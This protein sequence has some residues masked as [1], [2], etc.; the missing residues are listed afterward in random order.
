MNNI[1][2]LGGGKVGS[3]IGYDLSQD[4][5]VTV[6]DINRDVLKN[7]KSK[8]NFKTLYSDFLDTN[9][10]RNIL[11]EYDLIISAVP[12]FMG[13]KTLKTIIEEN[14]NVVDISFF[15]ENALELDQLAKKNN[16]TALV[17]FGVAP[18]LG[19]ILFGHYDTLMEIESYECYVGGL[20]KHK[21]PPFEYKAP[22]SPIDVI[23]EYTRPAR[24]FQNSKIITKEPLTDLET[25]EFEE[26]GELEAFNTD[27]LRSLLYTMSHVPYMKEKTLRYK[28]HSKKIKLLKD[29]GLF[30]YNERSINNIKYRPI[31]FTS[32]ILKENWRLSEYEEEFTVMRIICQ[33]QNKKIQI[34]LYDEYNQQTKITSMART[35]GYTCTAGANL[36][37][38]NMFNDVGV[39]PPELIGRKRI[40]HDFILNYIKERDINL[41][42]KTT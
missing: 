29:I 38:K 21:N 42:I 8:Y 22:F 2:V 3:A 17:D 6:A 25:I 33:N 5:S 15:P 16:I 10:L 24:F 13:F 32:D 18:G 40:C 20:P 1:L 37:L 11:K 28:G 31:D 19:N 34:D 27:G 14:K 41:K 36:V 23:E 35:T 4:Y 12:G 9:H 7:L 39:F 26:V 30:S